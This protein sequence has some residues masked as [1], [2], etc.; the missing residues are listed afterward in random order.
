MPVHRRVGVAVVA[1]TLILAGSGARAHVVTYGISVDATYR[2]AVDRITGRIGSEGPCV[3]GRRIK[4]LH[5]EP[6][7][8]QRSPAG[9]T[10]SR[11]GGRWK[12]GHL[13]QPNAGDAFRVIVPRSVAQADPG[14]RHTC[15]SLRLTLR[16]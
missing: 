16:V 4:V 12:V 6:A 13:P 1:V 2:S 14:H 8:G 10:T 9:S 3:E 5:L 7:S 11:P 15:R